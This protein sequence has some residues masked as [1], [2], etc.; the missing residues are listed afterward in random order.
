[1]SGIGQDPM[2]QL[3]GG[4]ALQ[5]YQGL[6]P[7]ALTGMGVSGYQNVGQDPMQREILAQARER[8]ARYRY[9]TQDS[10]NYCLVLRTAFGQ[11][12]W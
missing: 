10:K 5:A 7:S 2:S 8:F 11:S 1:M 9:K 12:L 3:L 4:Q 6:G